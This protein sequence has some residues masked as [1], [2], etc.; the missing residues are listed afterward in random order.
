MY[1]TGT[2]TPFED[3]SLLCLFGIVI[4]RADRCA[5]GDAATTLGLQGWFFVRCVYGCSHWQYDRVRNGE[6]VT[7]TF[8]LSY[9]FTNRSPEGSPFWCCTGRGPLVE[10]TDDALAVAV[11]LETACT[12][13]PPGHYS[14]GG[15]FSC[16]SA[17]ATLA[18]LTAQSIQMSAQ[19]SA[20][21]TAL[22]T[23]NSQAQAAADSVALMS[24]QMLTQTSAQATALAAANSQAQAAAD[25]VASMTSRLST[26]EGQLSQV[27][28]A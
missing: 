18:N 7:N 17:A 13:C 27:P 16:V 11:S 20:Q 3:I 10:G 28:L 15:N 5:L 12:N 6:F 22:A 19:M 26:A 21:A 14:A 24:T 23:A 25:S 8:A 2:A 1:G 9:P 4:E